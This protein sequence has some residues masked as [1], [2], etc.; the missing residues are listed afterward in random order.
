MGQ[1][2]RMSELVGGDYCVTA[3]RRLARPLDVLK[4]EPQVPRRPSIPA[5]SANILADDG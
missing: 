5:K 4:V 1:A 2:E 3:S